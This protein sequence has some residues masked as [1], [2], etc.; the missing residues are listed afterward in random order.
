MFST[1]LLL[2][3]AQAFAAGVPAF[4]PRQHKREVAGRPAEVIVL[5]SPHLSQ[6]PNKLDPKV[7]EPLLARLAAFKPDVI[8]IE[9]LS[10]EECETLLHFKSQH[11]VLVVNRRFMQTLQACNVGPNVEATWPSQN[12]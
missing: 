4:D 7:L 8:T 5:G 1:L 6:L 12:L 11:G 3:A 9:G 2:G 10:G